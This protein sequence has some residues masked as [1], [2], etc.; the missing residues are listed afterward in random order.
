MPHALIVDDDKEF[1]EGL[2]QVVE[3]EGFT[4]ATAASLADAR[5]ELAQAV[6][7]VVLLDLKLPDGSGM[8]LLE[9][10]SGNGSPEVIVITGQA[11]VETAVEAL[12]RGAVDYL[13][14]P[15]DF[16]RVKQVLA[17]LAR[18]RELKREIGSLRGELRRLGRFGPLIGASRGACS[19][20]YDLIAEVAPTDA[21]R[22]AS[23]R[24]AAPA[25][26]SWPQTIH[27]LSRRAKEPF[28]PR[29]LRRRLAEPDRERA[30]RPRAGQL[31]RRR[32]LAPR[33]LRARR[34]RHAVP[35][36]DHRDAGR[37]AGEAAARARD[38]DAQPR[39]RHRRRSTST[40]A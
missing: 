19:A 12:R 10:L 8:E 7:D 14:K 24:D 26:S 2:A 34:R 13:T 5:A 29:Q 39:R 6:P 32:P 35:R 21:T 27:A 16:G 15:V 25:R 38:R 28:V 33:L 1:Q 4:A 31:H 3:R 18:T 22:A 11:T 37:A 30:V 17:N 36:R 23:G 40:C 20:L 9:E